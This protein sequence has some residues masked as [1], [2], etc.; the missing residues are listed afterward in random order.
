M[1]ERWV[2]IKGYENMSQEDLEKVG[3]NDSMNHID[4]MIGSND[5]EIKGY[6]F[7]GKEHVIF[8]NGVWAI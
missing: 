5:L 6:D 3:F 2:D 7:D 4:F 8:K 1:I